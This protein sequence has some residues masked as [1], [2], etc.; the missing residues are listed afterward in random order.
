MGKKTKYPAYS[1]GSIT[2]NG[3]TVATTKKD[4][5]NNVIDSSYNMS[6]LEKNIYDTVQGG[7]YS[8]LNN[9][10]SVSDEKRKEWSN[11]L[12]AL[13]N[14]GIKEINNIYKPMETDL[15]NDIASRFGNLDNSIFL[16]RLDDITDKRAQAV[17]DLSENLLATQNQL[18]NE[19][20]ANQINLIS[21][22]SNLNSVMNNNILNYMNAANSNASSGNSYNQSQFNATK[23]TNGFWNTA[24]TI[25]DTSGKVVNMAGDVK[26]L[27]A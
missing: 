13:K 24:N 3:K 21:F 8:K 9:L 17:S 22:L 11:Q 15:K 18:Y 7:M 25:L 26:S 12:N 20:L 5:K 27:F 6:G 4:S 1:G 19:E 14:Q 2:V 23:A 10:F 16:D